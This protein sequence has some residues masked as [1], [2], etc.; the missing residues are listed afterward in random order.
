MDTHYAVKRP[1]K[2]LPAS[3]RWKVL[4]VGVAANAGF[5]AAAAGIPTTAVWMRAGYQLDNA[6]LGIALGATGLG[7]AL[8]ELPWGLATDRFGDR[9]VLVAGL[10]GTALALVSMAL[11]V[12][13]LE[14]LG[15]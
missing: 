15:G 5:S 11:V 12:V 10:L 9:P 14:L 6:Q 2:A 13:P 7:I 8:S 4:A 3:H 1:D